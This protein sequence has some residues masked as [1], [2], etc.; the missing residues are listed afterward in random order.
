MIS[1]VLAPRG[2]VETRAGSHVRLE[3]DDGFHTLG[4][5]SHHEVNNAVEHS[6]VG[7]CHR[8]LSVGGYSAYKVVYLGRTIKH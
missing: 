6:M 8:W 7:D 5:C 3:A 4:F 2:T 1:L